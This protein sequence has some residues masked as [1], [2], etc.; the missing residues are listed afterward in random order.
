MTDPSYQDIPPENIP[1]KT[2]ANGG[3]VR[4]IA[5]TYDGVTGPVKDIGEMQPIYL[6][7]T[8]PKVSTFLMH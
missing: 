5:G 3:K 8:L 4:I 2:L 1:E 7:V 6:D